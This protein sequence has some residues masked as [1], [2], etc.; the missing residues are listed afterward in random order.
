VPRLVLQSAGSRCGSVL[1]AD[2]F[3]EREAAESGVDFGLQIVRHRAAAI[4]DRYWRRGLEF[5]AVFAR[6]VVRAVVF[7]IPAAARTITI[8]LRATAAGAISVRRTFGFRRSSRSCG[9][10]GCRGRFRDGRCRVFRGSRN[11]LYRL[12][13]PLGSRWR[14]DG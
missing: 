13:R 5:G 12:R 9:C 7:V 10:G 4:G 3:F 8:A 1:A 6:L 14:D 2:D 11:R